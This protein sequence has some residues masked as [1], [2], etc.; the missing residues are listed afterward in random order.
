MNSD[1]LL[2]G[3]PVL[4]EQYGRFGSSPDRGV[5]LQQPIFLQKEGPVRAISGPSEEIVERLL[6]GM[7]DQ[8]VFYSK[9]E[10]SNPDF[11]SLLPLNNPLNRPST[12][13]NLPGDPQHS[14]SL[15]ASL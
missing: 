5:A 9:T 14:L 10:R 15:P 3:L 7:S 2:W 1:T 8:I 6:F 4:F 11:Y 13:T 12:T